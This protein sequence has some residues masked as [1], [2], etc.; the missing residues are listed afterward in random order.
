[1]EASAVKLAAA[2]EGERTSHT[3]SN[4]T[5]AESTAAESAAHTVCTRSTSMR[6]HSTSARAHST[7][8]RGHTT[9]VPAH[10]TT[11]STTT[12]STT[13]TVSA[14]TAVSAATTTTTTTAAT[15]ECNSRGK[16]DRCTDYGGD[17]NG[18]EGLSKHGSV[19]SRRR[20]TPIEPILAAAA[21][22]TLN[23]DL[24]EAECTQAH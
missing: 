7:T 12:V 3:V 4:H 11:V 6:A 10:T 19:S 17:S 14:T 20:A 13:T 9:T 15:G 1:V 23:A 8:V 16:G 2:M 21:Y 24:R 5:T 22:V 18:H